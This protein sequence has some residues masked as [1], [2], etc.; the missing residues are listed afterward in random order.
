MYQ[1]IQKRYNIGKKILRE[2]LGTMIPDFPYSVMYSST[3]LYRNPQM[4][5]ILLNLRKYFYYETSLIQFKPQYKT[6]GYCSL[7][8]MTLLFSSLK[9][10]ASYVL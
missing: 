2:F 9:F 7:G 10:L 4:V 6:K 3:N 8:V 5:I 1:I